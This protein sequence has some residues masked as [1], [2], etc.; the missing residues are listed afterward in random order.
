MAAGAILTGAYASDKQLPLSGTTS[1]ATTVA[2]TDP[3]D[4]ICMMRDG[5]A[6]VFGLSLV[7]F[8]ILDLGITG[9]VPAGQI[10][11]I[12]TTLASSYDITLLAL[13]PLAVAFG[14]AAT[15]YPALTVLLVGVFAGAFTS[16]LVQS[17]SF[18]TA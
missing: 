8:I 7:G 11:G 4:H 17:T 3:Y 6:A 9:T 13:L 1:L 12:Q 16:I 2:N 14:L 5:T 15:G 10:A 18:V